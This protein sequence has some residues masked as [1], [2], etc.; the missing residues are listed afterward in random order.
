[1]LKEMLSVNLSNA[2]AILGIR[3]SQVK[4]KTGEGLATDRKQFPTRRLD[5]PESGLIE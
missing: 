4:A 2:S 5:P 1:M 3:V